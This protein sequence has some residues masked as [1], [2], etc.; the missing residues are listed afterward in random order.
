[1]LNVYNAYIISQ[2]VSDVSVGTVRT[3]N[4]LFWIHDNIPVLIISKANQFINNYNNYQIQTP[5]PSPEIGTP[6][7]MHLNHSFRVITR[8]YYSKNQNTM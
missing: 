7:L 8:D 1:M 2:I 6:L 3:L 5:P 4:N